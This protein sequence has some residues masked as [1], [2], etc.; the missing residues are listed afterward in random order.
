MEPGDPGRFQ[1]GT[2]E[3]RRLRTSAM[4]NAECP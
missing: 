4:F 1:E 2:S 3:Y